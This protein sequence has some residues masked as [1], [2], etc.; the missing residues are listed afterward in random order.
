MLLQLE[1][2]LLRSESS[3]WLTRVRETINGRSIRSVEYYVPTGE[4]W[5]D[6]HS[7]S[8]VHE[9]DMAIRLIMGNDTA[10]SLWWSMKGLDEGLAL[11]VGDLM[12][13]APLGSP[14]MVTE[15]PDW[16]DA[17]GTPIRDVHPV[18]HVP[19]AGCPRM[20]WGYRLELENSNTVAVALGVV[21]D[22]AL[23]YLPTSLI[24]LFGG[25]ENSAS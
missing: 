22:D 24:V 21:V 20:P 8:R 18:F 3:S 15:H 9:V 17:T 16:V 10:L 6:G 13:V 5:P 1:P 14:V 7:T 23:Q 25:R 11:G 12:D 2:Q 19:N 4:S